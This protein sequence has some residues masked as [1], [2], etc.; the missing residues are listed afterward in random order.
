MKDTLG[1]VFIVLGFYFFVIDML[2]LFSA[3]LFR[4]LLNLNI[5]IFLENHGYHYDKILPYIFGIY[6]PLF[7]FFILKSKRYK[8]FAYFYL[9]LVLGAMYWIVLYGL[10]HAIDFG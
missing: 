3:A 6:F 1:K 7:L 9:F 10:S 5:A 8:Y 4:P 2:V